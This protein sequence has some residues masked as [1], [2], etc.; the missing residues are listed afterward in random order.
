MNR[1]PLFYGL[2]EFLGKGFN[3]W[4]AVIVVA[5]VILAAGYLV[6]GRWLAK[7]RRGQR[8]ATPGAP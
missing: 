4:S 1:R 5:A 7:A 3:E 6:Y 8:A 2:D